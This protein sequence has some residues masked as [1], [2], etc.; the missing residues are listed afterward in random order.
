[1]PG[2]LRVFYIGILSNVER[3]NLTVRSDGVPWKSRLEPQ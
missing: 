2:E 3:T 1:M